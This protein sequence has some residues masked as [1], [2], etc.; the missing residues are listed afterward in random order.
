M[1]G[2]YFHDFIILQEATLI[3]KIKMYAKSK[4]HSENA[5]FKKSSFEKVLSLPKNSLGKMQKLGKVR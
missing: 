4:T 1:H 3:H 5:K 2:G